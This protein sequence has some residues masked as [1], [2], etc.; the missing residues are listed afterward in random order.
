[1]TTDPWAVETSPAQALV[2]SLT[3]NGRHQ[4]R[5]DGD[6]VPGVTTIIRGGVPAPALVW[7]AGETVAKYVAANLDE[8]NRKL[9]IEGA[10]ELIGYLARV[11]GKVRD[12]AGIKGTAVHKL[13][14]HLVHGEDVEPATAELLT[15]A[16]HYARFLDRF[17]VEPELTEAMVANRSSW[18]AGKFDLLARIGSETWLLDVKTARGVYGEVSLQC[19]A[20]A[21]AEFYLA[22]DPDLPVPVEVPMPHIDRIGVIHC[23]AEG[24]DLHDLGS[25]T[26]AFEEFGAAKAIYLTERRRKNLIDPKRP[27]RPTDLW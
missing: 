9:Q 20:Y 19:A 26:E 6:W 4:Y 21:R 1:M 24:A 11:P 16:Q 2:P 14:E 7:W 18:Y 5:L 8:V 27:V 15:Y 22:T 23:T 13:A 12:Q 10:D 3:V 25:I 17:R